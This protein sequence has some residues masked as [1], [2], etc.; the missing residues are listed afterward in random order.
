MAACRDPNDGIRAMAALLPLLVRSSAV[1]REDA[2][3]SSE[4]LDAVL[5]TLSFRVETNDDGKIVGA[6][7]TSI[8]TDHRFRIDGRDRYVWCAL[9]TLLFPAILGMSA[10]VASVCAVSGEPIRFRALP[11]GVEEAS[12]ASAQVVLVPPT[13]SCDDLRGA[14]C[15]QVVFVK[16]A[17]HAARYVSTRATAW[18]VTLA[19]ASMLAAQM[20]NAARARC[21]P[22]CGSGRER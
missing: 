5:D 8:S 3:G 17:A 12:P 15:D 1:E 14:F 9:D 4:D 11:Q 20:A 6:G 7:L 21:A 19:E 10:D 18:A 22:V 13:A 16:D 2:S